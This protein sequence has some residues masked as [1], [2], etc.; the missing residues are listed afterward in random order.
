MKTLLTI[1]LLSWIGFAVAQDVPRKQPA[2][3]LTPL[4]TRTSYTAPAKT[5]APAPVPAR[6]PAT[7]ASPLYREDVSLEEMQRYHQ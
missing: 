5:T 6:K 4:I 2:Q 3:K 7:A 1:S